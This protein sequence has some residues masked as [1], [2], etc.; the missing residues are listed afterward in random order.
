VQIAEDIETGKEYFWKRTEGWDWFGTKRWWEVFVEFAGFN[1]AGGV[2]LTEYWRWN[3]SKE[4]IRKEVRTLS[5]E[6]SQKL[7]KQISLKRV[8]KLSI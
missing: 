1:G 6:D 8:G 7:I 5:R 4:T 3:S 2:W